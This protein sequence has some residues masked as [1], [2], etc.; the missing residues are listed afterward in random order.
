[1][2]NCNHL[3]PGRAS[4]SAKLLRRYQERVSSPRK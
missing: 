2:P 4:R 1:L 3:H